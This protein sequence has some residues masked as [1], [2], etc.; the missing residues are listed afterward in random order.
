L[1]RQV[2]LAIPLAYGCAYIVI[3]GVSFSKF[4]TGFF[5]A[6]LGF[7]IQFGYQKWLGL[8]SQQPVNYNNQV[9]TILIEISKGIDNITYNFFSIILIA[10]LYLGLF[11]FPFVIMYLTGILIEI[12]I[13]K[14][15][16]LFSTSFI[17]F[18][19]IMILLL[20]QYGLMPIHG[21]I[22]GDFGIGPVILKGSE[23]P[24]APNLIWLIITIM[25]ALGAAL[26]VHCL[27][28]LIFKIFSEKPGL[29]FQREKGVLVFILSLILIYFFPLPLVGLGPFGFYDRYLIFLLPLFMMLLL[30]SPWSINNWNIGYRFLSFVIISMLF[31]G[32]FTIVATHD[33]F[34][35]NRARWK[36]LYDL[37]HVEQVSPGDIDGGFEFNGWFLYDSKYQYDP[38]LVKSWYWVNND[39]YAV[40]FNS[41]SG[42]EEV[43]RYPYGSWLFFGRKGNILVLKRTIDSP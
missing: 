20:S 10:L 41:L 40:S 17:L 29:E 9:K 13:R 38:T 27:F 22:L 42:Y 37:M 11:L 1:T 14:R 23:L 19:I 25:S 8:E 39:R 6:L 34:A 36:A 21:N 7:G 18:L 26:L 15:I 5:P 2:G 4:I 32:W 30:V 43:N 3:K 31:C 33:Y 12:S 35:W 24:N 16:L 28:Y